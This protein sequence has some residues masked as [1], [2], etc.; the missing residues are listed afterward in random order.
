MTVSNRDRPCA[1][2]GG[3]ENCEFCSGT[4]IRRGRHPDDGGGLAGIEPLAKDEARERLT[5]RPSRG[6]TPLGPGYRENANEEPHDQCVECRRVLQRFALDEHR[7]DC[8]RRR[9]G[10]AANR[11]ISGEHAARN[12]RRPPSAQCQLCACTVPAWIMPEHLAWHRAW[13]RNWR[14]PR[15]GEPQ[16]VCPKCCRMIA[17]VDFASHAASP[18]GAALAGPKV[19]VATGRRVLRSH[20][21]TWAA[22]GDR[23]P[24]PDGTT[25]PGPMAALQNRVVEVSVRRNEDAMAPGR[26]VYGGSFDSNRRRH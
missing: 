13:E 25:G 12:G 20:V 18:H 5:L 23:T 4:K 7:A 16:A 3:N 1:C 14:I 17:V 22:P 24:R 26:F 9:D 19:E 6:A 21:A 11:A 8:A 2:T 10:R 15:P